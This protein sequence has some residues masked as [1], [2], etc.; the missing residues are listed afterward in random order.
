ME[1]HEFRHRIR[2]P[3]VKHVARLTQDLIEAH[4]DAEIGDDSKVLKHAHGARYHGTADGQRSDEQA[5]HERH[6]DDSVVA[7]VARITDLEVV[8]L[9]RTV[10]AHRAFVSHR[11]R[12]AVHC[13]VLIQEQS[14]ARLELACART[15]V[16]LASAEECPAAL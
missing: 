10:A 6:V 8:V 13:R 12:A 2:E 16:R 9:S 7:R 11:A 5:Q 1:V 3:K 15:R 4:E 14:R